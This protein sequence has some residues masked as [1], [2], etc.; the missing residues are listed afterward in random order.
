MNYMNIEKASV[1]DFHGW[2]VVL[3]VAGCTHKCEKCF[4]REAGWWK[5][6]AGEKF[7]EEVYQTLKKELSNS[8]IDNLVIQGGDGLVDRNFKDT[9]ALCK[10]LK[11]ELPSKN[12]VIF[13]GYTYNQIKE[14]GEKAEILKIIDVL[15]DGKY[16]FA[17]Y[18]PLI[19]Y[20]GSSNQR[21][22]WLDDNGDIYKEE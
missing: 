14:G 19:P 11:Q 7:S 8:Y 2:S 18:D 10:R 21:I 17:L 22:L 6:N 16:V 3:A 12:I 15:V 13:T 5:F 1:I 20:R 9:L 4:V